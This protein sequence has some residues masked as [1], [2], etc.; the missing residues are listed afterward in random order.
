MNDLIRIICL[1]VGLW[2]L[3]MVLAVDYHIYSY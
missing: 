3:I 1:V 2:I